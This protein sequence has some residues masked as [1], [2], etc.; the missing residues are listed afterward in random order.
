[1]EVELG[2][3]AIRF[4]CGARSQSPHREVKKNQRF[5]GAWRVC[6]R[7]D[8]RTGRVGRPMTTST[9]YREFA[10]ECARL[11]KQATNE[12]HRAALKEMEDA[13]AKLAEEAEMKNKRQ[14][15]LSC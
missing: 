14:Q 12:Q 5:L 3:F 6:V 2:S 7:N 4:C 13:W 1:M 10:Q 8:T 11:A 15:S 9:Q